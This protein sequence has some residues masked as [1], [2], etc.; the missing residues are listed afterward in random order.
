MTD[1]LPIRRQVV[2]PGT[3]AAAFEVFTAEIGLWWP[4]ADHSVYGEGSSVGFRD[5]RLVE[6]GPDGAEAVWGTPEAR[7]CRLESRFSARLTS[8]STSRS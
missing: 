2:V 3:P 6:R 5:G 1:L 8:A 7:R 4:L